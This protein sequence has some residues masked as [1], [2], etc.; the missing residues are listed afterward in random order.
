M[1]SVAPT[2][3]PP[4]TSAHSGPSTLDERDIMAAFAGLENAKTLLLAVS[5]GPDSI[6]LLLLAVRWVGGLGARAPT[7]H[8]ATVDHGLRPGARE[9]AETVAAIANALGL[10]HAILPWNG[11]KPSSRLQERARAARYALLAAQAETIGA[12]HLLTGH[13]AD[14]Q[15]ETVLFRLGRGSG[16]GG[17]AGMRRLS[18]LTQDISLVRPL[19]ELTKSQ[20][21]AVCHSEGFSFVDDPSNRD[22]AFA[23]ARLRAQAPAL[24]AL[25]LD[26][27]GLS[28]F[29]RRMARAND[30]L[31][32]EAV[33]LEA[34]LRLHRGGGGSGLDLTAAAAVSPEIRIRLLRAIVARVATGPIRLERL[35]T[36]TDALWLALERGMTY[37]ATLAG[38]LLVLGPDKVLTVAPEPARRRGLGAR[39]GTQGQV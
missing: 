15:A 27:Q 18:P 33:R 31:D 21:V 22:P 24:A 7:L 35:E 1:L 37:R 23:R 30:A 29:A 36:L 32:A 38:T 16:L 3:L 5:G 2:A 14:D 39:P 20:L 19:L 26:T 25:G 13:H 34:S 10:A 9:E 17:L 8:V 4:V 11:P 28:R 12:R 6:A